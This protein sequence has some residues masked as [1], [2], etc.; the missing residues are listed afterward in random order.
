MLSQKQPG[1][2]VSVLG[3]I[4]QPFEPDPERPYSLL[5]GGGVGI[6]P[7]V[8]LADTLRTDDCYFPH[9]ILG[10]EIP[11]PFASARSQLPFD[12]ADVEVSATMLKE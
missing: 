9:A 8:F 4:G 1:D 10:S 2:R 11:F 3:P 6:P 12:G 5:L 7:M